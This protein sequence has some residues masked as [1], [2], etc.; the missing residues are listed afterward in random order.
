MRSDFK[1]LGLGLAGGIGIAVVLIFGA[2]SLGTG[3][4]SITP[5]PV[6]TN[7][8]LPINRPTLTPPG[9][10]TSTPTELPSITPYPTIYLSPTPTLSSVRLMRLAGQ[11]LLS[12]ALPENQQILLY[13]SSLRYIARTPD[14]GRRMA[15]EINGVEY[16]YA[17]NTCGPLS[18][19]ILQDAGLVGAEIVPHD[20]WLLNPW[21]EH[22]RE[23]L[24]R[25]LPPDKFEHYV[26]HDWMKDFDWTAFSLLP[27]DFLYIHAGG[28]GN[29]DHMLVV[30]RVDSA[31]R[32]YSVTNYR[33]PD[34]F[35]ID[36]VMLYDPGDPHSGILHAW[37]A[38]AQ[39]PSGSTGFGGFEVWRPVTPVVSK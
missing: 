10:R 20:F 24:D 36:E 37:S 2:A 7:T 22:D 6:W 17:D 28:G 11:L 12:G 23:F 19:A 35:V 30:N 5:S 18:I 38:R 21:L 39:A 34:G 8:P 33:R 32:A 27:G 14:E 13:E 3:S 25:T 4:I 9:T 1:Y 29:F 16:G 15:Q 31:L 26:F